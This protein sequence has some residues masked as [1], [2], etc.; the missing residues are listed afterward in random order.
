MF[1]STHNLPF[2]VA[3]WHDPGFKLFRV[4]SCEGMWSSDSKSYIIV[5]ITNN[6][7]HNGHLNDCF[8]WFENSCKRDKKSLKVVEIMNVDFMFHLINKRGFKKISGDNVEKT[9]KKD[10]VCEKVITT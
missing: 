3:E 1:K 10:P 4:G 2:E 7:P 9:F 6:E 5:A 8:E